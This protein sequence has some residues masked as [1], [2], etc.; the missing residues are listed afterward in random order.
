M[1][2]VTRAVDAERTC[3]Q[4]GEC[5]PRHVSSKSTR[6]WCKG[7]V[8]REHD[9]QWTNRKDL[10]NFMH[11]PHLRETFT[12]LVQVK[13][14]RLC[15]KQTYESRYVHVGCGGVMVKTGTAI[16]RE[17]AFDVIQAVRECDT[18]QYRTIGGGGW[19]GY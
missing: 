11:F 13:V 10:P 12:V 3:I 16:K 8:G 4:V 15:T 7:K 2:P 9:W 6:R 5:R 1:K 17:E 18:C 14:C 19:E